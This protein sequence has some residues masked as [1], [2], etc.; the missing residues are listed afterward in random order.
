MTRSALGASDS[1]NI[2]LKKNQ[3]GE[4]AMDVAEK[5]NCD[6]RW[7]FKLRKKTV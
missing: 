3:D 4:L 6:A 5:Q 1:D 2:R 7:L